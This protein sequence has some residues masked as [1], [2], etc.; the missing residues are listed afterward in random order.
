MY[1]SQLNC[2]FVHV[3]RTGGTSVT[4]A[5][6]DY[7]PD[8]KWKTDGTIDPDHRS[9][10]QQCREYMIPQTQPFSFAFVRNPWERYV[11]FYG[12]YRRWLRGY[13]Q[14]V[15]QAKDLCLRYAPLD[16]SDWL[17]QC[18]FRD[19]VPLLLPESA[20]IRG[21]SYVGQ[22]ETLQAS[23]DEICQQLQLPSLSVGKTNA[24]GVPMEHYA[25]YYTPVLR[26]K[27]AEL[28]QEVITRFAY[29]FGEPTT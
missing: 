8:L 10:A 5:L 15:L 22:C 19:G 1:S 2:L 20:W 12:F 16:F 23:F 7:F 13:K 18:L 9:L 14:D 28:E 25:N 6:K 27:V 21:L 24:R 26:D 29:V 17:E 11:S 3:P 4:I